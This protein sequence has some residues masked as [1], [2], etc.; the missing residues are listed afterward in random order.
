[1]QHPRPK[2]TAA[3]GH[4]IQAG[5]PMSLYT[6]ILGTQ[7]GPST[8]STHSMERAAFGSGLQAGLRIT[9]FFQQTGI[10]ATPGTPTTHTIK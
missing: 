9:L 2:N 1:M 3:F 8:P 6:D 7:A 4:G 5:L 10:Q